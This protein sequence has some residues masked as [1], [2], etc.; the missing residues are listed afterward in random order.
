M[1]DQS[2]NIAN[3]AVGYDKGGFMVRLSWLYQG[4]TLSNV[5]SREEIDGYTD[6]LQRWDMMVKY[7][8]FDWTS[9]YFNWNNINNSA[10]KSYIQAVQF[11]DE[12]EF[13]GSTMDIGLMLNF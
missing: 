5:A 12:K 1:P 3:V 4:R 13:Y 9:I 8:I 10:D 6:A 11:P 7:K 2:D